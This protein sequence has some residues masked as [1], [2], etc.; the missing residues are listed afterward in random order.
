MFS[1][2]SSTESKSAAFIASSISRSGIYLVFILFGM[3]YISGFLKSVVP[4][5]SASDTQTLPDVPSRPLRL[6]LHLLPLSFP[7]D[8]VHV[9]L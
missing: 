4:C 9:I 1:F 5:L 2:S 3:R 8:A 7:F 6:D